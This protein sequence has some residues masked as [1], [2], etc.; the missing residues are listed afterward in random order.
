VNDLD[1]NLTVVYVMNNMME[2][3][4]GDRRGAELTTAAFA[5]AQS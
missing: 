1:L 5:A 4:V 3:L 2:G